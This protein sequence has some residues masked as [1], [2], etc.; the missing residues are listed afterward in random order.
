MAHSI[1]AKKRVRQTE[2]ANALNRWRLRAMRDAVKDLQDKLL[3]GT[4][5]DA[6]ASFRKVCAI[7]D[8]T[9]GKGVIHKNSAARK[10]S[11]LSV[12]VKAKKQGV[13]A[14]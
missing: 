9:A 12:R 5:A 7:I 13:K 14:S 6:E 11:R 10:K 2:S 1:S 3:H 8:K 4:A